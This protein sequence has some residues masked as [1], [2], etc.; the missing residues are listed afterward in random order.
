M[1]IGCSTAEKNVTGQKS[2]LHTRPILRMADNHIHDNI[3]IFCSKSV[4]S[5]H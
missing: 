4:T 1:L 5:E 3:I 2:K